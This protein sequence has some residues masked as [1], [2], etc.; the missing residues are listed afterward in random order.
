M[1]EVIFATPELSYSDELKEAREVRSLSDT[2]VKALKNNLSTIGIIEKFGIDDDP[3]FEL[4]IELFKLVQHP[5]ATLKSFE[6]GDL[7][8]VTVAIMDGALNTPHCDLPPLTLPDGSILEPAAA[9]DGSGDG[10]GTLADATSE[11]VALMA[12]STADAQ[13]APICSEIDEAALDASEHSASVIGVIASPSNG[14]GIVGMNPYADFQ[15]VPFNTDSAPLD[16]VEIV[17]NRLQQGL[18]FSVRVANLS[19]GVTPIFETKD[20]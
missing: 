7:A 19:F 5:F 6:E 1:Q 3:L 4:Q 11:A 12:A 16:Q 17:V 18:R 13:G 2:A 14:M 15:F 20:V 8:P 10:E 9:V